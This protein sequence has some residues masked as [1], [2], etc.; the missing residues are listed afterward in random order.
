[1]YATRTEIVLV[2]PSDARPSSTPENAAARRIGG[3]TH[4]VEG[5]VR[6]DHVRAGETPVAD[7]R[8]AH[9]PARQGFGAALERADTRDEE[10]EED[11]DGGNEGG[12]AD[13]ENAN[14]SWEDADGGRYGVT[15]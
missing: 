14:G 3:L 11:G 2:L 10:G 13:D 1:M 9:D 12:N 8:E 6:D 15:P 4:V 7:P 5:L